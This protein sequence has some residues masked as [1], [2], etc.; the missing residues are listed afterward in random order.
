MA[1]S[2]VVDPVTYSTLQ[3]NAFGFALLRP[4]ECYFMSAGTGIVTCPV[5]A[6]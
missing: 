2:P 6:R 4:K 1:G 3:D 5:A